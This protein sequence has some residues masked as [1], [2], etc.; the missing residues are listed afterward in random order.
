MYIAANLQQQG[1]RLLVSD[2]T[3]MQELDR[4]R[5][6]LPGNPKNYIPTRFRNSY[7]VALSSYLGRT[8]VPIEALRPNETIP[9]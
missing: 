1:P 8:I 9:G 7:T 2:Q 4:R 5:H 6:R 3:Y